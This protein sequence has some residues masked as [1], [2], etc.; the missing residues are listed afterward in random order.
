MHAWNRES[1]SLRSDRRM[2][3]LHE[4]VLLHPLSH[5]PMVG[6]AWR[7]ES[8]ISLT[9]MSTWPLRPLHAPEGSCVTTT[10]VFPLRGA[11]GKFGKLF[12]I[13]GDVGAFKAWR[14][15]SIMV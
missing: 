5:Q 11:L 13:W 3:R 14:P 2:A 12:A 6:E 1:S 10:R 9:H 7:E 4:H 8:Y 15:W